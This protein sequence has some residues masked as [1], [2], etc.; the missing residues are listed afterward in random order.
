M[1]HA[2]T[3][4]DRVSRIDTACVQSHGHAAL[5]SEHLRKEE[6]PCQATDRQVHT[7]ALQDTWQCLDML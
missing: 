1:R 7:N 3:D 2:R 5:A 6:T 4:I